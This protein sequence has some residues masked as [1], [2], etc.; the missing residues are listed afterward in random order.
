M[1]FK[2]AYEYAMAHSER[3]RK[4]DA[5]VKAKKP[6]DDAT[7]CMIFTVSPGET[8]YYGFDGCDIAKGKHN[9]RRAPQ[10][11]DRGEVLIIL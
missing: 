6:G 3:F 9:P 4:H 8:F 10:L 2:Q 1:T 11:I 5:K 7:P